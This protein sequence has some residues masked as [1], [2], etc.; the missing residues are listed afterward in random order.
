MIP[1]HP[2]TRH[3]TPMKTHSH[4]GMKTRNN[5]LMLAGSIAALLAILTPSACAASPATFT[6]TTAVTGNWNDNTKWTNNLSDGTAP[7]TAGQ[8]DYTLNF[9]AA[10]T[11]TATHNLSAGFLLNQLNLGGST[12]TLAGNSITFTA[13]GATLPQINQNTSNGVTIGTPVNLASNLTFGGSGS[14]AV[15]LNAQI[16][17][18]GSLTKNGAG[19]LTIN[20]VSNTFSGGAIIKWHAVVIRNQYL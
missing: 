1:H 9:N 12:V 14:G 8:A 3:H 10:G 11:Y 17:G 6:W 20:N 2:I 7:V 13:N 16:S 15:N 5:P 19:T 4:P 18:V